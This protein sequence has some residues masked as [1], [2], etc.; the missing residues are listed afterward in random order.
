MPHPITDFVH[1]TP[2]CDLG[3]TPAGGR[4]RSGRPLFHNLDGG[5][6]RVE[7]REPWSSTLRGLCQSLCLCLL[8]V[9]GLTAVGGC[10][11]SSDGAA[12]A[13]G[14][15]D[16]QGTGG[17]A[18]AGDQRRGDAGGRGATASAA[19]EIEIVF[20]YGSEKKAWLTE[21]TEQFNRQRI[22][23]AG[24]KVIRVNAIPM[25]SGDSVTRILEEE[26]KAHI[27]SPAS[28]AFIRLG[29][30]EA[31]SKY[32]RNL[33]DNTQDLVLSPVVIAM[34]RP[35]AEAIGWGQKPIGWADILDIVRNDQGWAAYGYPQWG[36][37]KFG[38]THPQYSNSGL[39]SL[40]AEVYAATGKTSNLTLEDVSRPETAQ[41][42]RDIEQSV[43][44]YGE[45]TGFFGTKM[46]AGGPQY[47]SAAVL[48]ENM[49]IESY[50]RAKYPNLAFPVVAIYPKEGTFWS[51]H[52]V[53]IVNADWV[54][55]EHREAASR[56]IEFLLAREQQERAIAFGFRPGD[57]TVPVGS[58]IDAAHGVD[59]MEPRTTLEVPSVAVMDAIMELWK[60]H[61]KRANVV[62]V[63]DVSGS[64]NE[65]NR[66]PSAKEGAKAL[67]DMLADADSVALLTFNDRGRT[68][69]PL[70]PLGSQRDALRRMIDSLIADGGTALY[71]ATLAAHQ[72]L[73]EKAE[74]DRI[75][76]VVVLTDGADRNSR[77]QL[78]ALLSSIRYDQETNTTRVFAIGYGKGADMGVL[79]Q[80]SEETKAKAYHGTTENIRDVFV[81]IS[82]FF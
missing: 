59:P 74:P 12:D 48:Y 10:G 81:A 20:P 62:L 13:A 11:R 9:V 72:M 29:N 70:A 27:V 56:Y 1:S 37:F 7:A 67:L 55:A 31:Q 52:P 43:V 68:L 21:A 51:D 82:T 58:P 25:G 26:L 46:F 6:P 3:R 63:M 42:L 44:H 14:G 5:N 39:I 41:F 80:I 24:G 22:T 73:E 19:A 65:E 60:V 30:A 49:I 54:T 76:A 75:S 47:L 23:T 71:D 38:H 53:G 50:D 78:S 69:Q 4:T 16:G 18:A 61:K 57:P 36:Q 17:S 35:M 32:G 79:E 77:M 40:F 45:S 33:V 28:A 8:L 15:G 2:A 64:M 66:L 34:W